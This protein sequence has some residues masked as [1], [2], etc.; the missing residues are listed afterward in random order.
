[1]AQKS[2]DLDPM[3]ILQFANFWLKKPKSP[4]YRSRAS[5]K[6]ETCRSYYFYIYDAEN[7]L[8]NGILVKIYS[9]E[10]MSLQHTDG[11]IAYSRHLSCS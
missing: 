5:C 7:V 9:E 6:F 2:K 8:E 4:F 1:M 10:F 3:Y 11:Q